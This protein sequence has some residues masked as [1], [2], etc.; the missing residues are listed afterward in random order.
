MEVLFERSS[1]RPIVYAIVLRV[2]RDGRWHTVRTFDNAHS[3]E[4][5]HE[6]AYVRDEKQEPTVTHGSIDDA[7]HAADLKIRANWR[8][9]VSDWEKAWSQ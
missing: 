5:H 9:I 4:E 2:K 7:M 6:H 3:P 8:D 1:A